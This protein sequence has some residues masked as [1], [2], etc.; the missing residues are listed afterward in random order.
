[1]GSHEPDGLDMAAR[2]SLGVT[3]P[4]KLSPCWGEGYGWEVPR[5]GGLH[6][7][8]APAT[9]AHQPR[10]PHPPAISAGR[11]GE[12]EGTHIPGAGPR[13]GLDSQY[14]GPQPFSGTLC[15]ALCRRTGFRCLPAA[16]KWP[17]AV[18]L[19]PE[20]QRRGCSTEA[21][22]PSQLLPGIHA[23]QESEQAGPEQPGPK[24][25]KGDSAA[26]LGTHLQEALPRR[27]ASPSATPT[28]GRAPAPCIWGRRK[29]C[30]REALHR[31]G[32]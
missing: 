29:P 4:E 23:N 32:S 24:Q 3:H 22:Q 15:E 26:L 16:V 10:C 9:S 14:G 7:A 20:A 1:M 27:L 31:Q 18:P 17:H 30:P 11:V 12:G 21:T 19:V 2:P 13:P 6:R 28:P 5:E 8:P 25:I